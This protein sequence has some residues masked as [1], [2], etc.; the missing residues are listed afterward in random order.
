MSPCLASEDPERV[1]L[2]QRYELNR[3]SNMG[4]GVAPIASN[5][6]AR[7]IGAKREFSAIAQCDCYCVKAGNI[8]KPAVR[9]Q[10]NAPAVPPADANRLAPA[11][12]RKGHSLAEYANTKRGTESF[13]VDCNPEFVEQDEANQQDDRKR[14]A[15]SRDETIQQIR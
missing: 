7:I 15:V 5:E 10:M 9:R 14:P 13:S 12:L 3:S 1:G 8:V 11:N 4:G 6:P 2:D